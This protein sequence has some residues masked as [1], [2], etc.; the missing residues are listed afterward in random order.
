MQNKYKTIGILTFHRVLNVGANLQAYALQHFIQN[1]ISSCEIIDF[2]PNNYLK[3]KSWKRRVFSFAKKYFWP[4]SWKAN[5]RER[6][7]KKFQEQYYV[8][9]HNKYYG[10]GDYIDLNKYSVIISGSDQILSTSISGNTITYYL[11][12]DGIKKISYAS[13]FGKSELLDLEKWAVMSFLPSFRSISFRETSGYEL[14]SKLIALKER[15]IV[16]DPV[17]LLK[18]SDWVSLT[19]PIKRRYI[20]VYAVEKTEWLL[21][22]IEEAKKEFELPVLILSACKMINKRYGKTITAFDP[23][24]FLSHIKNADVVIT[25]S[26]HGFAF[27]LIFGK[28][29]VVCAHQTRNA[30]ILSLISLINE[31]DKLITDKSFS[32]K[33]IDGQVAYSNLSTIID[34]SKK[35]LKRNIGDDND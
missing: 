23:K 12:F 8:L 28:K 30:R 33:S 14:A 13:S 26:Y 11:P 32:Y 2:Y 6:L 29:V 9:S 27:S 25:N 16:V 4:A 18:K 22:A 19:K 5:A 35:Y 10:D 24:I 21:K 31:Q 15:N 34:F 1:E 20:L 7:F 17:F 3:K